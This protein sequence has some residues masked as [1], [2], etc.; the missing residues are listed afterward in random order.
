M[1]PGVGGLG[2]YKGRKATAMAKRGE[3]LA[4]ASLGEDQGSIAD[5]LR[6]SLSSVVYRALRKPGATPRDPRA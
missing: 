6:V 4:L 2:R 5:E 1:R 3:V